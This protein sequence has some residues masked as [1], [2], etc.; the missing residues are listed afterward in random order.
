MVAQERYESLD[1]DCEPYVRH[2]KDSLPTGWSFWNVG[3]RLL[4]PN[5]RER[6]AFDQK[7]GSCLVLLL[8]M[9]VCCICWNVLSVLGRGSS[10]LA[11]ITMGGLEECVVSNFDAC[12][13][14]AWFLVREAMD[15][16]SFASCEKGRVA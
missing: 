3:V 7:C 2:G 12:K 5:G 1:T 11:N 4:R 13:N 15:V 14:S 6:F 10:C 16:P 8:R 9:I